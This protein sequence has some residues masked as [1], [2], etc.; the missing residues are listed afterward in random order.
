MTTVIALFLMLTMAVTL[1]AL[2]TA[3]AHT[4]PIS[5]PTWAYLSVQPSPVGVGQA[6]YVGFWID[7]A[8][9]TANGPYGDRWHN[10][11]VTVTKPN[12]NTETLGPFT[13]D[14]VG[15]AVTTYVP[16]TVGNY[17]FLFNFPGQTITGENPSPITGNYYPQFIGDYYLPSTS[18]KVV[19]IVQQ[20]SIQ[21]YPSTPL[22]TGYWQRPI[23]AQNTAWYTIGGNWLGSGI[24]LRLNSLYNATGNFN[25]FTTGP[26]TAH[27]V[28]TKSFAPGGLIGGEFGGSEMNSNYYSTAQYEIKFSPPIIIN[29]VLYYNEY[30]GSS[31]TLTNWV[32]VDLRT[33]QTIWTKNNA[34]VPLLLG[35]ILD[36]VSP[37]QYGGLTYLWTRETTVS[38]NT[39]STYGMY[40]ATTGKWILNIVNG[41]SIGAFVEDASGSLLGYYVNST[42]LTLNL[43]NSTKCIMATA[44]PDTGQ[45]MWRPPQGASI[46][47]AY[48]KQWSVPIPTNISGVPITPALSLPSYS[49]I[50]GDVIVLQS[51]Q[52]TSFGWG[53]G[54]LIEAGFRLGTGQQLWLVNRTY[55]NWGRISSSVGAQNGIYVEVTL[56]TLSL[57]A[58]DIKT[59]A[60]LWGPTPAITDDAYGTYAA[61]TIM[62]YGRVYTSTLG[63]KLYARNATTGAL[64]WTFFTG[65]SGYETPYGNWPLLHIDAVADGKLYVLGGHEYSPPLYHG[66]QLYCINATTGDLIWSILDFA[67]ANS[68]ATAMAD[69][70]L[71]EPNA[72]DNRLYCFG[73]G[74]SATTV[75]ASPEVSAYGDS[76]LIKGTVTDQ[77]PG[78]TCLGIPAAGTPAIADDSMSA[79]MEYLYEQQPMPTNATG[80]TVTLD[81]VDAN[82]NFRSIGTATTDTSGAFSYMWKPDIPGKYTLIATF[83]GSESY[84]ASYAETAFGV[85]EA[86]PATPP[87]PQYP[88]PI[89]YTLPIVGATIA[90][91]IAVAIVGIMLRNMLRKRP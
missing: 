87:P 10:F 90:I 20:E 89:D 79:W 34:S 39:G 3:N 18:N 17:T 31:N 80:V 67:N 83:Q 86:P 19:L 5:I 56:E 53:P 59:G 76:V 75:T 57:T 91:I 8:P 13:S 28:W 45:W 70:Y 36:Y 84:Y 12:G 44:A 26:N 58:Y 52:A 46:P 40:D 85:Q 82:G 30:P 23:F 63:G 38:P 14:D 29:G 33:G 32:A 22:P 73:K 65:S 72:Y 69:G 11:T 54:W 48:G 35:Q 61:S 27:I 88:V 64:L 81:V 66:A 74:Q 68:A 7:K 51:T 1:V 71:V 24:G 37:N 50:T 16:D 15:G 60:Q 62:A 78:Q 43:W 2:P 9:P 42:D 6:A 47:F 55:A 77:S 41:S 21:P 49:M 25:P 4:P